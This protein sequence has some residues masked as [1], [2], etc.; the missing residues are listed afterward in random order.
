MQLWSWVKDRWA[1]YKAWESK[2]R[3]LPRF[4]ATI[5]GDQLHIAPPRLLKRSKSIDLT[6]LEKV[7]VA[8]NESGPWGY[9]V[10]FVLQSRDI[11]V[12]FPLETNGYDEFLARLE[13]QLPGFQVRGMNSATHAWFECWP[14]PQNPPTTAEHTVLRASGPWG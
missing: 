13:Q 14:N 9:D 7:W 12:E 6:S 8:T 1:T 11:E 10:W 3:Q 2:R 4:T 5:V